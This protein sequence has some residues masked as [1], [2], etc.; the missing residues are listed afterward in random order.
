MDK[1]LKKE[2]FERIRAFLNMYF[3]R[4]PVVLSDLNKTLNYEMI[5]GILKNFLDKLKLYTLSEVVEDTKVLNS[6]FKIEMPQFFLTEIKDE[7]IL[8]DTQGALY[9]RY[10]LVLD[11]YPIDITKNYLKRK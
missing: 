9:I 3:V 4:E 1:E 10:A 7:I 2:D 6:N 5:G 8:V 11:N